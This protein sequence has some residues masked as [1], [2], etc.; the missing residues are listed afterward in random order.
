MNRKK[1]VEIWVRDKYI[2]KYCYKD[3]SDFPTVDHVK[4]RHAGGKSTS[5]NMVTACKSCNFN[6][7]IA[8]T[9]LRVFHR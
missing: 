8:E 6:K 5:E 9:P 2:C 1:K 3:C 7:S 4:P